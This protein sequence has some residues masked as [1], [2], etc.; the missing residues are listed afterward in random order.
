MFSLA[1]LGVNWSYYE[2]G[3]LLLVTTASGYTGKYFE[4]LLLC[5]AMIGFMIS[6]TFLGLG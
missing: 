1:V 4:G 3:S 5:F 6:A 2:Q